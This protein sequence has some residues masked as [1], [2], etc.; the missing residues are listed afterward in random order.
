MFQQTGTNNQEY[1]VTALSNYK[2]Q[3]SPSMMCRE[4]QKLKLT[5]KKNG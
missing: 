5:R 1:S 2:Q 4:L 3:V